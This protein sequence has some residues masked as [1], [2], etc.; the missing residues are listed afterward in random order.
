[1]A[2]LRPPDAVPAAPFAVANRV[3]FVLAL[4]GLLISG[5]LWYLHA[6]EADVPCMMGSS[7]CARVTSSRYAEFPVGSG[8]SVATYGAGG[9]LLLA[10]LAVARV[11][12]PNA[13]GNRR[14]LVLTTLIAA[15]GA[16]FSLR[17][18]YLALVVL[19]AKCPWCL[20]SQVLIL[21]IFFIALWELRRRCP[22]PPDQDR[23]TSPSLGSTTSA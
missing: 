18:T 7:D 23:A 20:T 13:S 21:S 17:L 16:I 8:I 4:V 19:H 9:Y 3:V 1:M 10:A 11:V 22:A 15:G 5:Y 12:T 14:L 2:T 6:V